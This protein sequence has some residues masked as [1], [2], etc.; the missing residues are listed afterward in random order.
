MAPRWLLLC[1][2]IQS[3][4]VVASYGTRGALTAPCKQAPDMSRTPPR[5]I[6]YRMPGVQSDGCTRCTQRTP[7]QDPTNLS[8]IRDPR[9]RSTARAVLQRVLDER[10]EAAR[11][12]ATDLAKEL[13]DQVTKGPADLLS[14]LWGLLPLPA[15]LKGK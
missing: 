9:V 10:H 7:S 2:D 15:F 5:P 14:G 6:R 1:T 3:D 4:T 11:K 8:I 13:A 12:A